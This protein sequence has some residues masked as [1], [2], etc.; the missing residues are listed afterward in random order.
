MS[1]LATKETTNMSNFVKG[2]FASASST[3]D[4]EFELYQMSKKALTDAAKVVSDQRQAYKVALEYEA[5]VK[6][7]VDG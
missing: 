5:E 3:A 4:K 2:I 6:K 1:D 7:L